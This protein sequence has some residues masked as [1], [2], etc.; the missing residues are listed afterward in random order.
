[1][2]TEPQNHPLKFNIIP[3]LHARACIY[4]NKTILSQV[5]YV[6][7]EILRK[8]TQKNAKQLLFAKVLP[9][10]SSQAAKVH[11][12]WKSLDGKPLIF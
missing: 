6:E 10:K 12:F 9:K 3:S 5:V 7:K 8:I 2:K 11:P 1:M 4:Y